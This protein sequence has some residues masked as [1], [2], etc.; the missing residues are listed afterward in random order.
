MKEWVAD[1]VGVDE[2]GRG[3]LAGPVFA[4]AVLL[5]RQVEKE[6]F[7]CGLP[8][9][10][11]K[12]LS[13]LQRSEWLDFMKELGKTE[14]G[15]AF[16]F[17]SVSEK[18][19]DETNISKAA[20]LAAWRACKKIPMFHC[21]VFLDA[22]LRIRNPRFQNTLIFS[23]PKADE[24]IPAVALASIVAKA[25][26]DRFVVKRAGDYPEYGF[27]KHKGYGTAAHL[28]ALK[29]YG[30]SDFHRKTFSLNGSDS[31]LK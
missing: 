23:M 27:A 3:A 22:G 2:A 17:A 5:S 24:N 4:A 11:S 9:R 16:S 21:P 8:L 29:Y 15:F 12:K 26:R 25:Q 28:K 1:V 31:R 10:D 7:N 14:K 30:V 13:P 20:D 19:I 18:L 6:I